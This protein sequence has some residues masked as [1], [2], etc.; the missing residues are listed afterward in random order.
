MHSM[1]LWGS[2]AWPHG[3]EVFGMSNSR[4]NPCR[5]SSAAAS[6]S[7][8]LLCLAFMATTREVP[9][10][11]SDELGTCARGPAGAVPVLAGLVGSA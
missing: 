6:E 8:S 7:N 4:S 2:R 9:S 5:L 3:S 10:S 11:R 1:G